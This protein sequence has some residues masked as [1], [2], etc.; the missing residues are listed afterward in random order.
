MLASFV[1]LVPTPSLYLFCSFPIVSA[2][3]GW[4]S[5]LGEPSSPFN[6]DAIFFAFVP[7]TCIQLVRMRSSQHLWLL[8]NL[9]M[10]D[11][12]PGSCGPL[13][14]HP[15]CWYSR[16]RRKVEVYKNAGYK[17][18]LESLLARRTAVE[19]QLEASSLRGERH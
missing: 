15:G 17:R 2:A 3:E 5:A 1:P 18:Y 9:I 7:F 11:R 8:S 14:Q 19:N 6:S 16:E 10:A 12:R 13:C 4:F